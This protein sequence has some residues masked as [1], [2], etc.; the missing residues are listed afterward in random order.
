MTLI[1]E[2]LGKL[3][4]PKY[5]NLDA[6]LWVQKLLLKKHLAKTYYKYN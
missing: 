3:F 6:K 4:A 1:L 2:N 5:K